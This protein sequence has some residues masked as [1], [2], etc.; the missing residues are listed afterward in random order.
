M[1]KEHAGAEWGVLVGGG[2]DVLSLRWGMSADGEERL[3]VVG[4][5]EMADSVVVL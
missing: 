4:N 1:A 3:G 2:Q 5:E